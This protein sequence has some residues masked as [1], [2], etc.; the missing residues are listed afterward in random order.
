M[1]TFINHPIRYDSGV[2]PALLVMP[3]FLHAFQLEGDVTGKFLVLPISLAFSVVASFASGFIADALGRKKF[4]YVASAIHMTG[5]IVKMA[6]SGK[7][8]LYVGRGF[9][10]SALGMFSLLVPLYQSEIAKPINRGR[11][12]TFYQIFVTMGFC[13]A[14]WVSYVTYFRDDDSTWRIPLSV[15]FIPSGLMLLGV[16]FIPESPRWLIYKDRN[17]EALAILYQLRSSANVNGQDILMEFYSIV[18]DVRFDKVIYS[19]TKFFTLWKKGNENNRK[20]TLLGMGVHVFTQLSGINAIL[21]YLPGILESAGFGRVSSALLANGV[22]GIL[23]FLPTVCVLLFIDRWDRRRILIVGGI[24]MAM[25]MLLVGIIC[26]IFNHKLEK[27]ILVFG[28]VSVT[29]VIDS[30]AGTYA[31]VVFLYLFIVC[32]ACSWGPISWIYPAEIYPQM[33]RA[34]ALGLTTSCSYLFTLIISF[35]AP[36]MFRYLAWGTYIFF[37]GMCCIMSLVVYF[38]FPETRVNTNRYTHTHTHIIRIKHAL[39]DRLDHWKKSN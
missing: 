18:Q 24:G 13:I 20:R 6:G 1:S 31:T 28:N 21:Y 19:S 5:T 26:A 34:N 27:P 33:I 38:Y 25:C 15:Q 22:A 35:V 9:T 4:L 12:I 14:F 32:F 30:T 7:I 39:I 3:R 8:T 2:I 36:I 11:L 10:G 16:Y 23:N 37:A 17:E 29:H